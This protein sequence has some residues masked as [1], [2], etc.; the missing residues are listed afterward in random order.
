M[1]DGTMFHRPSLIVHPSSIFSLSKDLSTPMSTI[2]TPA[3]EIEPKPWQ[4]GL[5]PVY[6]GIFLWI[7]FFD[8]IGRN[9]LPIGSLGGSLLG[10]AIGGPLAYLCLFRSSALWGHR[11]KQGLDGLASATFGASG[12]KF[13]P[14]LLLG[15]AQV[16]LFSVA[17]GYAVE[18]TFQGLVMGGLI[19]LRAIRPTQVDRGIFRSPLYL[20]TALFWAIATALV[21]LRFTR[22]IGYLMQ[23][24]PI[25]PA[26]I[27]GGAMLFNLNGLKTFNPT[28]PRVPDL[29][30]IQL[31]ALMSLQWVFA[32]SSLAGVMGADWGLG[33]STARDVRLGGWVGMAFAPVIVSIIALVSIAG[34]QG[35]KTGPRSVEANPIFRSQALAI[36]APSYTF[37]AVITGAFPGRL[38]A[39][40]LIIFGLGSLAPAVYASFAFG[41]RFKALGPGISRL[42]WTMMGTCTAWLL[43]VGGWFERTEVTFNIL[44]AVFAPVAG[45]F[46][47]DYRRTRG[48]WPGPRQGINPAGLLAWGIGLAIGL[49]PTIGQALGHERLAGFQPAAPL[50]FLA[51]YLTYEILGIL[52]FES[53]RMPEPISD[54]SS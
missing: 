38:G 17:L 28:S 22:W 43:V 36:E 7:G 11:S 37:R 4:T 24:F 46:A 10:L 30:S 40:M 26:V 18:M 23:F 20:A 44:G 53:A 47:A 29:P 54:L 45:A 51:S 2:P 34:Y 32:F 12:S 9:S 41:L 15:F 27:L 42:T 50:A 13:V 52:R 33:S 39:L 25:F 48:V 8:Q 31:A 21:S 3:G 14:G 19:D 6:I 1:V 35:S 16:I 49:A 5:A